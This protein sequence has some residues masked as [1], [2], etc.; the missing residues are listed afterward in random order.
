MAL[1]FEQ[2]FDE[3]SFTF[4]YLLADSLSKECA[5]V[6]TVRSHIEKYCH[7]LHSRGL[8][9]KYLLETH[10]HADHVTATGGLKKLFPQALIAMHKDAGLVQ[11]FL[12]LQDNT[13]LHLGSIS[14]E[15]IF[16]PGHTDHSL[17]FYVNKD[18]I[19]S[20]DTLLIDSCGRTDFQGGSSRAMYDTLQNLSKFDPGTLVYPGHDYKGRRVSNISEQLNTNPLLKLSLESFVV[21]LESWK[22]PHPKHIAV[23]VPANL[24]CGLV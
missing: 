24:N 22:L 5:L 3:D 18:R 1:I 11:D 15:V 16:S 13:T 12:P 20:G 17:S 8:T 9:L 4:S 19:L 7:D 6:D 14:V 2:F 10:I 23:A 21:E